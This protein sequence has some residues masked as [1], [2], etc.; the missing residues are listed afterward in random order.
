MAQLKE[1]SS[2]L[3]GE[4]ERLYSKEGKVAPRDLLEAPVALNQEY[5]KAIEEELRKSRDKRFE[6][7]KNARIDQL[8]K[9]NDL[10]K[11]QVEKGGNADTK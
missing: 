2:Q 4:V 5:K 6:L 7:N 1:F 9:E 11:E 8:E 3:R 10:L